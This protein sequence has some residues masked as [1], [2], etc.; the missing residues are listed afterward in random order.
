[1]VKLL[2][3][4]LV[5]G[6]IC[7]IGCKNK[8]P[9]QSETAQ[10]GPL[11]T[12]PEEVVRLFQSYMDSNLFAQAQEISTPRGQEILRGL[13]GI[14]DTEPSDSTVFHTEFL[15]INCREVADTA[16]CLCKLKDE[17]E[18]YESEY[19]LLRIGGRWLVD[20]PDEAPMEEEDFFDLPD[21]LIEQ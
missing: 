13:A 17:Y 4:L 16:F 20:A 11:A 7:G 18:E 10:A 3:G 1:M 19:I 21:S 6:A 15:N 5:I 14:V 2:W 12:T 9:E 8:A